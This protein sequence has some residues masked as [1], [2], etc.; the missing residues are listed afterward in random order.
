MQA[1]YEVA[2][3]T[4][5]DLCGDPV[6]NLTELVAGKVAA[7]SLNNRNC[8]LCDVARLVEEH[9]AN[10]TLLVQEKGQVSHRFMPVN[11]SLYV[12][13]NDIVIGRRMFR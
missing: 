5:Y 13:Q 4:S 6:S 9:G 3:V 2:D 12:Q 11:I 10:A 8:S 1:F 7:V